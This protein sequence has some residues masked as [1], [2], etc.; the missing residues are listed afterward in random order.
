MNPTF[1]PGTRVRVIHLSGPGP[2]GTAVAG[3]THPAWTRVHLDDRE[4][5]EEFANPSLVRETDDAAERHA[6]DPLPPPARPTAGLH[7]RITAEHP[8]G[9]HGPCAGLVQGQVVPVQIGGDDDH[10][11]VEVD[12]RDPWA[13]ELVR[14]SDVEVCDAPEDRYDPAQL[15]PPALPT[16]P[17]MGWPKVGDRCVLLGAVNQHGTVQAVVVGGTEVLWDCG[18]SPQCATTPAL[19]RHTGIHLTRTLA[20]APVPARPSGLQPQPASGIWAHL[21]CASRSLAD[22]DALP[23]EDLGTEDRDAARRQALDV[24]TRAAGLVARIARVDMVEHPDPE[25]WT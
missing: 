2:V 6:S 14:S 4:V 12:P 17:A 19:L 1:P 10:L 24:C 7:V 13:I 11:V 25:D 22:I 23:V 20:P 16:R 9:P 15:A 21:A 5:V 3:S 18:C 8:R